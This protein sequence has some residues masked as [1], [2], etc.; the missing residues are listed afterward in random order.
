MSTVRGRTIGTSALEESGAGDLII[1][2]IIRLAQA[3]PP[4]HSARFK[5]MVKAWLTSKGADKFY[6]NSGIEGIQMV[7]LAKQIMSDESIQPRHKKENIIRSFLANC[8]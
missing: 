8:R 1:A 3:A 6:M 4:E 7:E 5:S 2:G